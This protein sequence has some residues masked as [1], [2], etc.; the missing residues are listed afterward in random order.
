MLNISYLINQNLTSQTPPSHSFA[1]SLTSGMP[2]ISRVSTEPSGL[3][4]LIQ[5]FPV[6]AIIMP[7]SSPFFTYA[8]SPLGSLS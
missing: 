3:A 5:L 8:Q 4:I 2:Y 1:V 7:L 6:S